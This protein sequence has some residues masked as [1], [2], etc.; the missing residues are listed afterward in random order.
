MRVDRSCPRIARLAFC[1]LPVFLAIV[2][3]ITV[4]CAIALLHTGPVHTIGVMLA[5]L[6]GFELGIGAI[7]R[8]GKTGA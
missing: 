3:L 2:G 1:D 6:G 5:I 8:K 4:L 7:V